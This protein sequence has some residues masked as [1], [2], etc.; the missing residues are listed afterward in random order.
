MYSTFLRVKHPYRAAG[1]IGH[2]NNLKIKLQQI[3]QKPLRVSTLIQCLKEVGNGRV[4]NGSR[5][6]EHRERANFLTG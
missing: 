3:E 6:R 5:I 4:G 1:I 2:L